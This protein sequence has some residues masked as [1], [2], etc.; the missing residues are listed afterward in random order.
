MSDHDLQ[1][2]GYISVLID[3]LPETD[4]VYILY[5]HP[6]NEI[7]IIA[8]L[9]IENDNSRKWDVRYP[10]GCT[11]EERKI[12]MWKKAISAEYPEVSSVSSAFDLS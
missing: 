2:I 4:G 11:L 9:I 6:E 3:G 7:L 5:V 8:D 12:R 10:S 1:E